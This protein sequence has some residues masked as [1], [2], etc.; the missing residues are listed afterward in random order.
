MASRPEIRTITKKPDADEPA[1]EAPNQR[2]RPEIGAF[3]LQVDRQTKGSYLTSEAAE[4]VGLAIKQA[5][6]IVQVSIYNSAEG[7]N[8]LI[9]LPPA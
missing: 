4:K 5:H 2:A 8:K 3:R 7:V 1:Q 6:P 9:E